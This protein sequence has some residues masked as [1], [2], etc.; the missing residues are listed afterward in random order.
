MAL[1]GQRVYQS[2]AFEAVGLVGQLLV[3]LP[4]LDVFAGGGGLWLRV[5][6]LALAA[7]YVCVLMLRVFLPDRVLASTAGP[8]GPLDRF[9]VRLRA[10]NRPVIV[11]V[12]ALVGTGGGRLPVRG[13]AARTRRRVSA[14]GAPPNLRSTGATARQIDLAW[15]DASRPGHRRAR[16][17]GDPAGQRARPHQ[18]VDHVPRHHRHRRRCHVLLPRGDGRRRRQ[19]V[20]TVRVDRDHSR[21]PIRRRARSTPPR[22]RRPSRYAPAWSPPPR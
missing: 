9:R 6:G 13:P 11:A 20:R 16:V 15:D 17:P 22:R 5:G 21:S 7:L 14:P 8:G 10:G 18:C 12:T 3:A 19:R 1:P 4:N 2:G